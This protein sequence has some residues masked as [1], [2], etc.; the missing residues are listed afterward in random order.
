MANNKLLKGFAQKFVENSLYDRDSGTLFLTNPGISFQNL[1][2]LAKKHNFTIGK[3]KEGEYISIPTEYKY[4]KSELES[5]SLYDDF[6]NTYTDYDKNYD[7]LQS[8]YKTFDL[9]DENLGEAEL[10]LNTYVAE[11]LSQGFIDNPLRIKISEPR[12]QDLIQKVFYKNKIYERLPD[13]TRSV[14]KYGN[15]G[16]T[17]SYPYL[18]TMMSEDSP[19][20]FTKLDVLEDLV[21]S[22]VNPKN[23]KVHVDEYNNVINYETTLGNT[24]KKNVANNTVLS[25]K[26]WQP[27]Q[28]SHFFIPSE[29]TEPYGKSMLWSMRSAFDQ[30]TTLEALLAISRAGKVQRLVFYVPLPNGVNVIDSYGF[31]NQFKGQYLSSIFTDHGAPKAGRKLPGAM[32][33]L[34]LPVSADG[35]KVEVDKIPECDIDLSSIEDVQYF[36]DKI[37]RNSALPKG[38]LIGED[39]ITT[40]QALEAQDLKLRRTLIPLKRALLVGMMNLVENVLTHAG[41]DVSKLDVEISMNEPIQL[42]TEVF[43]KYKGICDVVGAIVE[44]NPEITNVNKF[45]LF[46]KLG[47]PVDIATLACSSESVNVLGN[48]EDL[49]KFLNG[50]KIKNKSLA[51]PQPEEDMAENS[52]KLSSKVFLAENYNHGKKLKEFNDTFRKTTDR[53]LKESLL[54]STKQ[55]RVVN[56]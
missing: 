43:D 53:S 11:V 3:T 39:V 5:I 17:L 52:T 38:Y 21:I 45:Q 7:T 32:S 37:L 40:A 31:L 55:Q 22:F 4:S 49:V 16:M 23:F 27:W 34:T 13:I 18:E 19:V 26:I 14:A 20:D 48:N 10:I 33:I 2:A 35:K 29:V 56:G 44:G 51:A 12:A 47:L 25:S 28:F 1:K 6:L 42:P 24:F 8:A 15:Y 50:K 30:L 41:Y 36:L 9:M 46:V 54:R